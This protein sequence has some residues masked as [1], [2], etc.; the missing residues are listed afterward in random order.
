M[1]N[2]SLLE[3]SLRS[4]NVAD[5]DAR[6]YLLLVKKGSMSVTDIAKVLSVERPTV[7]AALDRLTETGLLPKNRAGTRGVQVEP[8]SKVAALLRAQKAN[9]ASEEERL[10]QALPELLA[11]FAAKAKQ[12]AFRLYEGRTQFL[13]VFEEVLKEA[14]DEILFYGDAETFFKFEG[15]EYERQWLKRRV[16]RKLPI[17]MLML[18]SDVARGYGKSSRR[19]L[20]ESRLLGKNKAFQSSL[21][22]Y[23]SKTVLW[24]PTFERA[25]VIEDSLITDMFRYTFELT[26]GM[27]RRV[28]GV[29]GKQNSE[30]LNRYGKGF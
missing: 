25:I 7:Y 15:A 4:L 30:L 2:I 1:N 27:G 24:N 26:W 18:P 8:P 13:A 28:G 12:S 11:D 9:L 5:F 21:L 6:L 29:S 16:R 14:T 23:G 22:I 10:N 20:R 19:L 17:R 3:S